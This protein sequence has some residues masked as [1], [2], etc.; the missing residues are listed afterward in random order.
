[1]NANRFSLATSCGLV[2]A[3]L[4]PLLPL[5]LNSD[6]RGAVPTHAQIVWGLLIHWINLF[7]LLAVLLVWERRGLASIGIRPFRWSVLGLGLLAG[8]VITVLSNLLVQ[9]LHLKAD[10][11]FAQNLLALPWGLRV[12]LVLTA[13]VFEET[14]FRGYG[15]ERLTALLGNR[16]WAA[17]I[18]WGVFVTGHVPAVGWAYLPPIAIVSALITLLYLWKKDLV[19]NMTAHSTIDGIGLLL[20][21]LL[22]HTGT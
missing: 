21:P 19:L 12:L 6:Y 7:A 2:L 14:L 20:A 10:A 22:T 5:V 18:T 4:V 17:A 11:Q 9:A 16:W 1:M 15:I 3:L 8:F 13:G